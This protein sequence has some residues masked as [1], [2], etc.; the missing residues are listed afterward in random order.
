MTEQDAPYMSRPM[1]PLVETARRFASA[2]HGSMNQRRLFTDE[3]YIVHPAAVAELISTVPGHQPEWLMAAYLHDVVEDTPVT[4][5]QIESLFGTAVAS[6]VKELTNE[7]T[8]ADGTRTH[9][10]AL[11]VIRLAGI[12]VVAQTIKL[13]DI[14]DNLRS[15][16]LH[17][18]RFAAIYLK[19]K[20][21]QV[22]VLTRGDSRLR[23]RAMRLIQLAPVSTTAA[24]S[25]CVSSGQSPNEARPKR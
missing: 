14:C 20:A 15:I 17:E 13:A 25:D 3:P 5:D 22:A 4:I 21:D 2:A 19:E 9:R 12:S 10:K 24:E 8:P 18:P 6:L 11:D 1:H 7:S 23:A 16:H